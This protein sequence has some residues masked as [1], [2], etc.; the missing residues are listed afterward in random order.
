MVPTSTLFG[1]SA[2]ALGMALTP[3][4]NMMYLASRS[5]CQ[6]RAAGLTSL[7]G[8]ALGFV[9]YL[10]LSAFGITAVA[11]AVPHA[12][13]ALRLAGAT[14]LA[15]LAWQA[16]RPGAASPFEVRA[17]APDS[18]RR[19]FAMGFLTNLLNPK[20]A[21]LYLSL[22]PQFVDPGRGSVLAQSLQLGAAQIAVSMTVNSTVVWTAGG[23]AAFLGERPSWARAQRFLMG[24]VLGALAARMALDTRR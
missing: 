8:V 13:D 20:A 22:L 6:G 17:L 15:Y 4:P 16:L 21:A 23:I 14:Y 19:L 3:G 1:F 24:T 5:V 2:V 18:P 11:M 12:Y 10:L 9:V 7:A